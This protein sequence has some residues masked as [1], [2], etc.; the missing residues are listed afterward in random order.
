MHSVER[1]NYNPSSRLP[2]KQHHPRHPVYREGR[3][4][5]LPAMSDAGYSVD[6]LDVKSKIA[7][8]EAFNETVRS[9]AD[10]PERRSNAGVSNTYDLDEPT[11][12]D[13]T[14]TVASQ[15][16]KSRLQRAMNGKRHQN[17]PEPG[18]LMQKRQ[19]AKERRKALQQP[20]AASVASSTTSSQ[21]RRQKEQRQPSSRH[22]SS[23]SQQGPNGITTP[24]SVSSSR[25]NRSSS[26]RSSQKTPVANGHNNGV[27]RSPHV[28]PTAAAPAQQHRTAHYQNGQQQ[29][30]QHPQ[31]SAPRHAMDSHQDQGVKV[32][33]SGSPGEQDLQYRANKGGHMSRMQRLKMKGM[34][35][36]R[37][38]QKRKE[39]AH[40]NARQTNDPSGM[41]TPAQNFS[42]HHRAAMQSPHQQPLNPQVHDPHSL[43]HEFNDD[44]DNTLTS[45]ARVV[46]QEQAFARHKS[47]S[48]GGTP[49]HLHR[50]HHQASPNDVDKPPRLWMGGEEKSD[51]AMNIH[52][53]RH[54]QH[55]HHHT[56]AGIYPRPSSSS[57]FEPEVHTRGSSQYASLSKSGGATPSPRHQNRQQSPR[58]HHQ[59]Q[60]MQQHGS[61]P[62]Y[63][64]QQH[65]QY[66]N[67][68]SPSQQYSPSHQA[69]MMSPQDR[70]RRSA[71]SHGQQQFYQSASN[72]LDD[73]ERTFD[74]GVKDDDSQG[75]TTFQQQ[76]LDAERKA[77]EQSHMSEGNTTSMSL[78]S[79]F[80]SV[81]R[82]DSR[83]NAQ[84]PLLKTGDPMEQYR[85]TMDTPVMK[86]TCGVVGAATL[87]CIVIGPV[88]ML[89]GAAAVG[90]GV[91]VM[92][93][94]EEQRSNMAD[95]ATDTLKKVE[96]QAYAASESL[97]N[98][99]A[100]TYKDSGISEH[101]P[102]EMSKF[103]A[104]SEDDVDAVHSIAQN[105]KSEDS[106]A[107]R[108]DQGTGPCGGGVGGD[109]LPMLKNQDSRKPASPNQSRSLRNKKVACLR[110]VKILPVN[111]IHGM[112]PAHQP[113]AWLDVLAS[114]DTSNDDKTEAME[115]ILILAKDKQRARIFLEEGILDALMWIL[116]RFFEKQSRKPTDEWANPEITREELS[117]ARLAARCCVT[118]GK[119]HC[120]AIHTEGDLNLMSKYARGTVPE[121]RQLAQ[122]LHEVPHHT[123]VT[124]TDDPTLVD[125]SMEVFA[126]QQLTL[127]KAEKMAMS[128]KALA[129]ER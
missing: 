128:V 71:G 30:Q 35:H 103:C 8:F 80:D 43:D 38:A 11:H 16:R 120:A 85:Q 98:S 97:S 119:S 126:L 125:P 93:I 34:D 99:C 84:S 19:S 110:H 49:T 76:L 45:V 72:R 3:L 13:S 114:A 2:K 50:Q 89:L 81:S 77:R 28:G 106:E 58:H 115:E 96:E 5:P 127:D 18:S 17:Q 46:E 66:G 87:G 122:M 21:K 92:Q 79:D 4:S 73:D 31:M 117:A 57:E 56:N 7:S 22:G 65:N 53:P 124:K 118:L 6:S 116:C 107:V 111:E 91:G 48:A 69:A 25:S 47:A 1:S 52:S 90:I 112:D 27:A 113:R 109:N 104:V 68:H 70:L 59:A 63:H 95:K 29:H 75:S 88:G 67:Y 32:D 10:S 24:S 74:Y 108:V 33:Y 78:H 12:K 101:I 102:A 37:L 83:R 51:K 121:E 55:P 26:R 94:P 39:A 36:T 14:T 41:Q 42:P 123:R 100:T 60:Q 40:K 129:D 61:Q 64:V 54:H 44:D 86:T 23:R 9:S 62:H 82:R 20:E 105:M 15:S